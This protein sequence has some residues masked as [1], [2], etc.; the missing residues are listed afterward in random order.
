MQVI[1][2]DEVDKLGGVGAQ[3]RVRPGYARNYLI[4]QGKAAPVTPEN[5]ALLEQRRAELEKQVEQRR[6]QAGQR[7]EELQAIEKISVTANVSESGELYGS[8]GTREIIAALA[9]QGVTV[10]KREVVLPEGPL[11]ELGEHTVQL[12]LHSQYLV[13]LTVIVTA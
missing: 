11:R 10:H 4:P 1:L 5:L 6:Q 8:V 12:R 7:A 2:L 3:V 13:P 9:Q